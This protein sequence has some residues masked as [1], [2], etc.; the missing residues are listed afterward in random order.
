MHSFQAVRGNERLLQHLQNAAFHGRVSH[1]Y[2]LVGG[3]GIGKHTVASAFAKLLECE[4]PTKTDA[5]Q[6]CKSCRAFE[7]GNHPDIIWVKRI[8]NTLGVEIIKEQILDT[9]DYKPYT[10]SRKIYIIEDAHTMTVQAQNAFLKT[11]EEP[12]AYAHFILLAEREE[13]FLSTIRSRV[14]TLK[15]QGVSEDEMIS[16]LTEEKGLEKDKS[17]IYAAYAQGKIGQAV[18]LAEEE[19]FQGMR[20]RVLA[21]LMALPQM[22]QGEAL[23]LAKDLEEYK[24]DL[25]FLDIMELW[26]RDLLVAKTLGK[27]DAMIQK[28]YTT[29]ILQAARLSP[30]RIA[31][32]SEAIITAKERLAQN[33]NFRLTLEVMLMELKEKENI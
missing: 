11:L 8:K 32:Q 28:D 20:E 2:L 19:A 33:G 9:I 25:R 1:A 30:A 18:A 21:M 13:P 22:S 7:H 24:N 10:F 3:K 31:A 5:C 12:P 16:Y 6:S 4:A 27:T 29:E 17:A 15:L 26:Y 23:L 14:V